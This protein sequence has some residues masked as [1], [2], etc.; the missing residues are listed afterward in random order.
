MAHK[1]VGTLIR[2]TGH[3][4][5]AC[6]NPD[7]ARCHGRVYC[8]RLGC[9]PLPSWAFMLSVELSRIAAA[10]ASLHPGA[11][12]LGFALALGSAVALAVFLK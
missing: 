7:H 11:V 2:S 4:H 8:G 10:I 9:Y 5:V 6:V 12:M 3:Q 1:L